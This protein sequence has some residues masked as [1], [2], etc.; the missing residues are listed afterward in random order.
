MAELPPEVA[1]GVRFVPVHTLEK[2]LKVALPR[3]AS[4][5]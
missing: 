5:T 4:P 3:E 1:D 2:V